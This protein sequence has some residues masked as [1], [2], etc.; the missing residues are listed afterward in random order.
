M[1]KIVKNLLYRTPRLLAETMRI[2]SNWNRD[3]YVFLKLLR[4]GDTVLIGDVPPSPRGGAQG[5][6]SHLRTRTSYHRKP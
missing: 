5:A 1:K 6:C 3:K 2:K 4:K